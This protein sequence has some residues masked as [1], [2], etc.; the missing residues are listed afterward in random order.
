MSS[1]LSGAAR[2][3]S[4][5]WRA[6]EMV[7]TTRV[8]AARPTV[9]VDGRDEA[10][11]A[12][13]LLSMRVEE[14][15]DGLY[16]CEATFGNWGAKAGSTTF[17][18]FDRRLLDFGKELVF[19]VGGK[20]IFRG[21]ISALE[22]EFPEGSA[23]RLT[24][25]AEDRYADLRTKRRTRTFADVT[26][27]AVV[28]QVATDHGLTAQVSLDGPTHRVLAQLNQS[29][30][31]FLRDR[32]RAVGAELWMDGSALHARTR[33]DRGSSGPAPVTLG[34]GNDLREVR[35]LAD[36]AGQRTELTVCGW[37]VATKKA[38][39][40]SAGESTISSELAG[41]Q[42]GAQALARLGDRKERVVHSV[43]VT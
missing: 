4:T 37:D 21:R 1:E 15:T 13:G 22:G 25:L 8:T 28:Q 12:E 17:L 16:R 19:S 24:V 42:S 2:S 27:A 6:T 33:T 32:A 23:P 7:T 10:S 38:V 31:A 39:A 11:L 30:L 36:L 18:Y 9:S 14:S 43:P 20:P 34:Y 5:G 29:D 35:V 41:G 3:A 40:E 26:D